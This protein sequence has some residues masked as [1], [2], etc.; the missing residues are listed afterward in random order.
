[1]RPPRLER[2]AWGVAFFALDGRIGEQGTCEAAFGPRVRHHQATHGCREWE[3]TRSL[4]QPVVPV[5]RFGRAIRARL[6][7]EPTPQPPVGEGGAPRALESEELDGCGRQIDS[8]PLLGSHPLIASEWVAVR[9]RPPAPHAPIL[10]PR[11]GAAGPRS[12]FGDGLIGSNFYEGQVVSKVRQEAPSVPAI[13]EAEFA[14]LV[15]A[16]A[17]ES[18]VRS[19][20]A[21]MTRARRNALEPG[22]PARRRALGLRPTVRDDGSPRR[23]S[24]PEERHRHGKTE[25]LSR[26]RTILPSP[27]QRTST[28]GCR[29]PVD[30]AMRLVSVVESP[31]GGR[32]DPGRWLPHHEVA[33]APRRVSWRRGCRIERP[34]RAPSLRPSCSWA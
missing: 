33:G 19:K 29:S 15:A 27:V 5:D 24:A 20:R 16:P 30:R 22:P 1:M 32:R 18:S 25:K 8:W 13:T 21:A 31:P 4:G 11:A 12:N 28:G 14:E 2:D 17:F 3:G 7:V 9:Q 23:R 34:F 10:K 6:L 26:H